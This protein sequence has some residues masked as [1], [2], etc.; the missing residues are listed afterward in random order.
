[1]LYHSN[2]ELIGKTPLLELVQLR[3]K[4]GFAGNIYAKM[5]CFNPAGS[6][7]DRAVLS[8]LSELES[9][10]KISPE[11]TFIEPTSGN[12]G[13]AL[14]SLCATKGYRCILT[15][16]E[17]MSIER[18][19]IL[20]AYGAELVLT[21]AKDGMKGAIA[22]AD[23]LSRSIPNSLILGQ[24]V[25]LD[26][27]LGHYKTTGPEIYEDLKGKVDIFVAGIGTGGTISGVGKYL[28]EQNPNIEIVGVEPKG[29]PVLSGGKP[30][31]H[32]LMGIG[33]GFAPDT[34]NLEVVDRI[35]TVDEETAY[36]YGRLFPQTE[37]ILIGISSGAALSVAVKLAKQEE[38]VGKNIVVLLPDGGERYL[39][40]P[41]FQE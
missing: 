25:N 32:G 30:G 28:K 18:R 15:M 39:S 13:I 41:L 17:S 16:P 34:L 31:P 20:K 14:A 3:K 33:A 19:K 24:F 5:E 7:K 27:P 11:T 22:K 23:E 29:S 10:G 2:I 38:N 40:S 1:M 8:M 21:P 37:G 4:L 26:N 36:F 9:K 12:T 6:S 35:E